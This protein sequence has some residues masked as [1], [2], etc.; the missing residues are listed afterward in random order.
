[1]SQRLSGEGF[2]LSQ[3]PRLRIV[4]RVRRRCRH[5]ING[6]EAPCFSQGEAA[7]LL[8]SACYVYTLYITL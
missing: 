4:R 7:P 8:L 1:M 5:E 2:G 3:Q 6:A